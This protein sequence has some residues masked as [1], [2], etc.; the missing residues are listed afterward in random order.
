[1]ATTSSIKLLNPRE[2]NRN[3]ENPR[4]IFHQDELDALAD[5]ISSQGILVPLTV[6]RDAKSYFILDGERRWR[7]ALKLGFGTVPVIVQ[8]KPDRLQNLMM[9]FAIHHRRHDWDPLPTALKL[10]DLEAIF[11]QRHGRRPTEAQLAEL[12]SLTRGEVRRL[13]KLLSLP[14]EYREMLLEE[15]AKPRSK[16][17]ITVDHVLETTTAS[18]RLERWGIIDKDAMEGLSWAIIDK[19]RRGVVNNTTAP[20][21]LLRLGRAVSRNE[22][23]MSKA[24][25]LVQRLVEDQEFSIDDAFTASVEQADFEHSLEQAI[26]RVME[27]LREH[28][29]RRYVPSGAIV[30][31]LSELVKVAK[32]FKRA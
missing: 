23:P 20:R 13:K 1:M 16:Q 10:R 17:T 30:D 31:A 26:I 14:K 8:P 25:R 9:M 7:C 32:L 27:K 18:A 6:Y 4:L 19:F 11:E 15:L 12:A 28:I 3:P 2:L 22:V 29:H 24:R 5:S 21:K